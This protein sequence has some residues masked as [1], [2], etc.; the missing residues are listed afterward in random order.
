MICVLNR[1]PGGTSVALVTS[2]FRYTDMAEAELIGHSVRSSIG[3]RVIGGAG[4]AWM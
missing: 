1:S 3:S 2:L 4:W